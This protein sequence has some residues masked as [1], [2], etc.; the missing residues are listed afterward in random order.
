MFRISSHTKAVA[1]A[2][3]ASLVLLAGVAGALTT[4]SGAHHAAP[5][6]PAASAPPTHAVSS[7]PT[8]V[9]PPGTP[10]SLAVA[11]PHLVWVDCGGGAQCATMPVPLDWTGRDPA[12]RGRTIGIAL[13]RFPATGPGTRLG[14]LIVNPGGPGESGVD[15]LRANIGTIP[16]EIRARFDLVS[17]DPRGVGRS[18]P[19]RCLSGPQLDALFHLPPFPE[20]A[21]QEQQL[22]A[23]SRLEANTCARTMGDELAHLSTYE[24][25]RD[26]DLLRAAVGDRRLTYLGY[27]YGT[28]IGAAYADLFPTH[29][30]AMVLDGALDPRIN[31]VAFLRGQAGGFEH[32]FDAWLAWCAGNSGCAFSSYGNSAAQLGSAYRALLQRLFAHPLPVGARSLGAGEFSNG[33]TATLYSRAYGWPALG[34]GLAAAEAGNGAPLLALSDAYLERSPNGS[35]STLD[36]AN[37]AVNCIDRPWPRSAAQY[38]QLAAQLSPADPYFGAAIAWSGLGCA[39][40]PVPAVTVPHAVH[41]PGAPPILVIA[42]TGDPATPYQ[43]G[44]ALAQQLDSG[45]L[46]THV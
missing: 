15:F 32:E 41:A 23:G 4:T 42:T 20:N 1:V 22:I 11:V 25:A 36:E 44:V 19:V 17:F 27:S 40:W 29:I 7:A 43:E 5:R 33:V 14:S 3:A 46:L 10:A 9:R 24:V 2:A 21:S 13:I 31:G 45:V 28:A 8:R 16:A 12:A 34:Q 39:Y 38:A 18:A 6:P 26:L 30:R 37:L 35:Y